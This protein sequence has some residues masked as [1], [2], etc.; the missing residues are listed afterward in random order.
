MLGLVI[1]FLDAKRVDKSYL[2]QAKAR[3]EGAKDVPIK[4]NYLYAVRL[5]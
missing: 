3:L 1:G 5:S 4:G 2:R